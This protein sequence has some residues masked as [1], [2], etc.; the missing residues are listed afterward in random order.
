MRGAAFWWPLL[1][2]CIWWPTGDAEYPP[3]SHQ[4]SMLEIM[5]AALLAQGQEEIVVEND[6]SLEF[7]TLAR[8]W[9]GIVESELEDGNYYFTRKQATLITRKDGLFGYDDGFLIPSDALHV[10]R[11]W[12]Q[13]PTCGRVE[14]PWVQDGAYVY[15]N[16]P[17]GCVIE[18][19]DAPGQDLWSANFS[20]GVQKKLE[21]VIS[22]AIKEEYGDA[23][24]L[25]QE[26]E[27]YFQRART[28]SS[29][30]R[31]AQPPYK[32]GPIALARRGRRG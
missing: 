31:S 23:A 15:L 28:N 29:K 3:M 14:V 9:P 32:K 2:L 20:R 19:V 27:T 30:A 22:R 21:A 8:N 12:L 18:Y 24:V 17:D 7:Q 16:S 1:Q 5:N 26:A 11:L 25:E 6:G 10:R 13:D 4:Y